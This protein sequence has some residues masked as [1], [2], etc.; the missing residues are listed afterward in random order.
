MNSSDQSSVLLRAGTQMENG[1]QV[2]L[3]VSSKITRRKS[4]HSRNLKATRQSAGRLGN[5]A[6]FFAERGEQTVRLQ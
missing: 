3:A 5:V 2:W 4:R 1:I 6:G